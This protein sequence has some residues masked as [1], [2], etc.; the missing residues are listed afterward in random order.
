MKELMASQK[1]N[2]LLF[3]F[4]IRLF[5]LQKLYT[6]ANTG[7]QA[8]INMKIKTPGVTPSSCS[9]LVNNMVQHTIYTW[10]HTCGFTFNI[11][12]SCINCCHFSRARL[13]KRK[14]PTS[15]SMNL[16]V[17]TH[18]G[19]WILGHGNLYWWVVSLS[20]QS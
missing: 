14:K 16:G 9:F 5:P 8:I 4:L 1:S 18:V 11:H 13:S 15:R 3:F 12:G 6:P 20:Y 7:L 10:H 2:E 17:A 19:A